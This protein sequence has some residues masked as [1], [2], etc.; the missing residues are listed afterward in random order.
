[1][2]ENPLNHISDA[3]AESA[4]AS[5]RASAWASALVSAAD[6]ADRIMA[7]VADIAATK[8]LDA[9]ADGNTELEK[10]VL[11]ADKV[12]VQVKKIVLAAT[13]ATK[14]LK[15]TAAAVLAAKA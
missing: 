12:E 15:D 10:L 7:A 11:A 1:M 3:V 5:A 4:R 8:T 14:A 6:V 13:A 2:S 9:E